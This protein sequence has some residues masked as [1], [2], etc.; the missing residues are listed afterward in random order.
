MS[1]PREVDA[2]EVLAALAIACESVR[3]ACDNT[4]LELARRRVAVLLNNEA[5]LTAKPWGPVSDAQAAELSSWPTS[6]AFDERQKAALALTEQFVIDVT[7]VLT[8]P[9]AESASALGAEVGPFVQALYLLDVGQRAGVVLSALLGETVTTDTWAWGASGEI[10]ADPMAAIMDVLAATG[11]LQLV[12]PVT[13]EL[14]RLRGARLHQCRRCQSVRSV[15][16]LNAGADAALLGAEDPASIG[17]LSAGTLAVLDLVDAMFVGPPAVDEELFSR[18]T[19][20]YDSEEL[21]EIVSYL[22]RNACNKIPVA[23]GADDAIVEE[24]FEYQVIDA[25]GETVTVDASAL[26][27]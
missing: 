22:M 17:K 3:A 18:L 21:V 1:D 12:D 8:G 9:L 13:K 11:R 24:G 14:M 2:P 7:G 23:F 4:L 19:Q 25:S 6:E 20:S 10:P 16:A 27:N 15:A 26:L 5:E